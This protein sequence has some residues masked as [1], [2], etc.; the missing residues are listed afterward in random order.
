MAI[1]EARHR[2]NEKWNAQAYDSI[3]VRVKK[4]QKEVIQRAA[5]SNGE[6]ING[7]IARLIDAELSRLNSQP[8]EDFHPTDE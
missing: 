1:S 8:G 5:Q 2:A 3:T 4:G 6:S 7:F